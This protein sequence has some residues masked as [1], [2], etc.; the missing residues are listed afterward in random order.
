MYLVFATV[1]N[2]VDSMFNRDF[3]LNIKHIGCDTCGFA[4]EEEEN[5]CGL[6]VCTS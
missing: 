3:K 5:T 2:A 4:K 1:M 6:D